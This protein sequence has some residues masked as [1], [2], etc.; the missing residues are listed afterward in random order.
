MKLLI[1]IIIQLFIIT[2]VFAQSPRVFKKKY[3]YAKTLIS[4]NKFSNASEVLKGIIQPQ[5]NNNYVEYANYLYGFSLYHENK[6]KDCERVLK[7]LTKKYPTWNNINEVWYLLAITEF[8]LDKPDEALMYIHNI[9]DSSFSDNI[10]ALKTVKYSEYTYNQLKILYTLHPTDKELGKVLL[11]KLYQMIPLERDKKLFDELIVL[12]LPDS[13]KINAEKTEKKE[14]YNI[15]VILPFRALDIDPNISKRRNILD[16][17]QGICLAKEKLE[18]EGI[19]INIFSF[20]TEKDSTKTVKILN[21]LSISTIDLIIGPLYANSVKLVNQFSKEHKIPMINPLSHNHSIIDLNP[22]AFLMNLSYETQGRILADFAIDSL[23]VDSTY[24]VYGGNSKDSLL[25][26]SY[27]ERF[28]ER[29]KAVNLV[30]GFDYSENEFD[31]L[32]EDLDTLIADSTSNILISTTQQVVAVN[33]ISALQYNKLSMP[34]LG[35]GNWLNFNQLT[36][37]QMEETNIHF[38]YPNYINVESEN[39]KKWKKNYFEKMSIFPTLYSSIGYET[40]CFWGRKLFDHGTKVAKEI[41]SDLLNQGVIFPGYDFQDS[42]DNQY[43]PI[44]KF[45]NGKLEI[46]RKPMKVIE[47]EE[48]GEDKE[49][50][51]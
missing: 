36:F 38:L 41:H 45:S 23:E 31:L 18:A 20:D 11:I 24:I 37:D 28:Q 1:T 2:S 14:V 4:E 13:L 40:M 47:K 48:I 32:L 10:Y 21:D 29:N 26:R 42:N 3:L 19:K 17:Y 5:E 12:Y 51:N 34:I 39:Y 6:K 50:K 27:M 8:D 7:Q 35:F 22:Y 30:H 9:K 33:V 46:A 44:M 49:E 25:A 16:L 15:A 43:A